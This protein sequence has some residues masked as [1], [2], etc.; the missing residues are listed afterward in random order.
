MGGGGKAKRGRGTARRR[1]AHV[2]DFLADLR[3][4]L[5]DDLIELFK[6]EQL[7]GRV[8]FGEQGQETG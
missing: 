4:E 1:N 7:E 5:S 8:G 3:P 2:D 6:G